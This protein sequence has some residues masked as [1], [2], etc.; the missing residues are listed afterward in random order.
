MICGG[1]EQIVGKRHMRD[2]RERKREGEMA[3]GQMEEDG[4]AGAAFEE[5][6]AMAHAPDVPSSL[7]DW[8]S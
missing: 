1:R 7:S 4:W 5:V 3:G 6:R 2:E 8:K